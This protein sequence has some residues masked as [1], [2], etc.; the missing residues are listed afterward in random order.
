MIWSPGAAAMGLENPT[1]TNRMQHATRSWCN[2]EASGLG[3]IMG[4]L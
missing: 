4:K 2:G 3:R 1:T